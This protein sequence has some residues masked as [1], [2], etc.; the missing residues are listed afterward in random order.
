MSALP[1]NALMVWEQRANANR[2]RIYAVALWI[3]VGIAFFVAMTV[4]TTLVF[5]EGVRVGRGIE[6]RLAE[7]T[8]KPAQANCKN[9]ARLCLEE[10]TEKLKGKR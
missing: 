8:P 1:D 3:F 4:W 6:R 2:V 10:H 7:N 5:D 9:L